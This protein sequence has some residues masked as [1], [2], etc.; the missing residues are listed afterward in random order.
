MHLLLIYYT[1]LSSSSFHNVT[2][3]SQIIRL[4]NNHNHL[5][6]LLKTFWKS[7]VLGLVDRGYVDK[8]AVLSESICQQ[9]TYFID[10]SNYGEMF[11]IRK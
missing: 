5:Y 7:V 6:L 2:H 11:T 3:S 8:G 4:Q 1:P 9:C 10:K